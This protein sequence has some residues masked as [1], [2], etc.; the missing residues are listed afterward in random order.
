MVGHNWGAE[1]AERW[2]WIQASDLGG[3]E[4][5]FLDIALGRIKVAGMTTPWVANGCIVL[6]GEHH[7][8]GGFRGTYGTDIV[9][10]RRAP[11]S[12]RC[13]ARA[14]T[15]EGRVERTAEGL[16]RLDL[17]GPEGPGAQHPQLLDLRPRAEGRARRASGTRDLDVAGAAAYELGIRDIDHGVPLQ[18]YPDG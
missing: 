17:R 13:R 1:H 16:R 4:G 10:N 12:S 14:S 11:A 8:V 15:S 6:D 18:P 3:N 9:E 2:V 7:R 5:D